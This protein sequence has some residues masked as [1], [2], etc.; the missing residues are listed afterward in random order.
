MMGTQL[1]TKRI[2]T[3]LAITFG[4]PWIAVLVF[5]LIF[6]TDDPALMSRRVQVLNYFFVL[7]VPALANLATRLITKEGWGHLMLRLNFRSGWRFYLAAWLLP[8]LAVI[9]GGAVYFLL[10]P[11][12]FDPNLSAARA[13]VASIPAL[14]A[15]SPWSL[16]LI[17]TLSVLIAGLVIYGLI[18]IGEELGWRGY[19]LPKLM[20]RFAGPERT[21]AEAHGLAHTGG[22]D[23]AG[24]R[25]AAL[26]V[27]LI[28]GVWHWPGDLLAM[29]L[30]PRMSI[31]SLLIR[32]V[33]S[34]VL[35]VLLAWVTLRSGSVWPAAIGHGMF[36]ATTLLTWNLLK[37]PANMLLG[38]QSSGLIG[39]IGYL[40]LALVLLY[41]RRAFARAKET[42][43]ENPPVKGYS[44][45]V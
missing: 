14:A 15:A 35:S 10:F 29:Q 34:C 18:S 44:T 39:G 20:E 27:G 32:L 8:L 23:A 42:G 26:L 43:S 37:G 3:Y 19:L 38:P 5:Y 1:N 6:A 2:L 24:A 25:K 30:D 41:S 21:G 28:W 12:S 17:S 45:L 40:A 16:L 11:Q 22:S 4:I 7:P 13:A 31:L 33:S 9:V 36:N